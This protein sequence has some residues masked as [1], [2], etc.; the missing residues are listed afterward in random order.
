MPASSRFWDLIANSYAKKPVPDESVYRE[1][2]RITREQ[3]RPGMAVLEFGCGS[4]ITAVSHAPFVRSIH[5]I[6]GSGKLVDI[7]RGK[8]RDA[9]APNATFEHITI[10]DFDAP[11]ASF[12]AVLGLNV[13]HLVD[14]WQAAIRKAYRL[15]EPGGVFVSSTECIGQHRIL[16]LFL[17]PLGAIGILPSVRFFTPDELL[18]AHAQTGFRI[19]RDW[20]PS[21][22]NVFLVARKP[23]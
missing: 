9:N 17:S 3:F 20:R 7:A 12:G 5:G 8:A 11:D 13:L 10:E 23:A 21:G 19:E 4:G 6:D 14:D 1:K 15:L 16:K 18:Q 2:L 22:S